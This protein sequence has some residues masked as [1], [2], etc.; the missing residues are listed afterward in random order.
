[1]YITYGETT[2]YETG[3]MPPY[4]ARLYAES[5]CRPTNSAQASCAARSPP[6]L[7]KVKNHTT[8]STAANAVATATG[9]RPAHLRT[10]S[11]T[12][13]PVPAAPPSVPPAPAAD[14]PAAPGALRLCCSAV[15]TG[16]C[17][18][19]PHLGHTHCIP[20]RVIDAL[21]RPG[22]VRGAGTTRSPLA[23]VSRYGSAC[24]RCPARRGHAGAPPAPSPGWPPRRRSA[25]R[26]RCPP[27]RTAGAWRHRRR[28]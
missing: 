2:L 4:Q 17:P 25:R 13:L 23:A 27:W 28:A 7:A 14:P 24:C 3:C 15:V 26:P 12:R 22:V 19:P 8:C 5:G 11:R 1:M 16:H 6:L 10:R 21:R 20:S 9:C 18:T